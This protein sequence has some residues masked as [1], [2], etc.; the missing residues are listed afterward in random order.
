[1]VKIITEVAVHRVIE[2]PNLKFVFEVIHFILR[3]APKHQDQ[4]TDKLNIVH[5]Y[6]GSHA[7]T[8]VQCRCCAS[9]PLR[10]R[11]ISPTKKSFLWLPL[12]IPA[13]S[14]HWSATRTLPSQ[15]DCSMVSATNVSTPLLSNDDGAL[16]ELYSYESRQ[17]RLGLQSIILF[18]NRR[19]HTQEVY[20]QI[21]TRC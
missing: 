11:L 18:H 2:P 13:H 1:M 20:T 3:P 6:S 15:L 21:I 10:P 9:M 5:L 16:P 19:D 8:A 7:S 12:W 14:D 4:M 17:A